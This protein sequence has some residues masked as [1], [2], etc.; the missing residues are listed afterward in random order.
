MKIVLL[1]E[2]YGEEEEKVGKPFVGTSGWIL[3]QMLDQA[4]IARKDCFIT[5][6]FNLRPKPNNNVENLCGSKSEGIPGLPFLKRGKY[7][8]A[9]YSKE[10]DRL[11][12]ELDRERPNVIVALGATAAWALCGSSGIKSIRGAATLGRGFKVIPTYHPAAVARDWTLRP[13]V[14]SD[15]DKAKRE[16]EFPE[17]RRPERFIHIEPT[18]QDLITF[19][20]QYLRP[21][22]AISADIETRENQIT[23]IGFAPTEDRCL[24][25][26]F[27]SRTQPDGNYWRTL[28]DEMK[29]WDWVRRICAMNKPFIFQ[30]GIYDAHV[31]WKQYGIPVPYM[32]DDTMLMHHALQPEMEKGLGF[33]GSVYTSEAAWKFMRHSDN[34]TLKKED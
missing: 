32:T 10:L 7:V 13:I 23:C 1:G 25:V 20:Y 14:I 19:E 6:V 34:E 4:G 9:E 26:P 29:A 24:V 8:R 16:S 2:A 17:L 22:A 27:H 28:D 30:N 21:A 18:L 15:L 12:R 31:L 33:L 11:W 5:N 3:D